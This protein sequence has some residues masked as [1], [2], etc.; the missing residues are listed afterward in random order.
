M[1]VNLFLPQPAHSMSSTSLLFVKIHRQLVKRNILL[2]LE[3]RQRRIGPHETPVFGEM[4]A[5]TTA[6]F[7]GMDHPMWTRP[8][9]IDPDIAGIADGMRPVSSRH[10]YPIIG[11]TMVGTQWG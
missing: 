5:E 8:L 3:F 1:A 6:R 9:R 2:A 11:S 10:Q 7:T 4:D